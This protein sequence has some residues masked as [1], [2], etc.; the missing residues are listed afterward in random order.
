MGQL[1]E[2]KMPCKR[3]SPNHM[4]TSRLATNTGNHLIVFFKLMIREVEKFEVLS[5]V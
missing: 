5:I 1:R 3:L 2:R 4:G